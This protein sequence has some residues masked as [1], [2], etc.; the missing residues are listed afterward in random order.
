[1]V[2]SCAWNCALFTVLFRVYSIGVIQVNV[3]ENFKTKKL[4]SATREN[5]FNPPISLI[6]TFIFFISY[7]IF[8][9]SILC[10]HILKIS[11]FSIFHQ[12]YHNIER[13]SIKWG[14]SENRVF[15]YII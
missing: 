7:T 10:R 3:N 11:D 2:K 4:S 6:P 1:M 8:S 9:V 15:D 13:N 12:K 14:I 5:I